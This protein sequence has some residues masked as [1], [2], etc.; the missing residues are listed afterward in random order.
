MG[1]DYWPYGVEAN[2]PTLE[3]FLA[4]HHDQGLSARRVQLQELF[5]P[6]TYDMAR[7]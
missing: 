6:T 4:H 2:R 5:A 1:R 7:I 3:A